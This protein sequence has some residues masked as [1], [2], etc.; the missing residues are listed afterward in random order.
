MSDGS[1][2]QAI[3]AVLQ[4]PQQLQKIFALAQSLGLSPPEAPAAP[5]PPEPP[6]PAAAATSAEQAPEDRGSALRTLLQGQARPPAGKPSQRAQTI[7]K[8]RATGKSG[9]RDAGSE[10][11]ASCRCSTARSGPERPVM[12][13]DCMYNRYTPSPDGTFQRTVVPDAPP[14]KPPEPEVCA[15]A[16]EPPRPQPPKPK[17]PSAP[18]PPKP[19]ETCMPAPPPV[20]PAPCPPDRPLRKL[21]PRG[22]DPGDLL[23][24]LVLL[25]VLMETD[26]DD[27]LT[28]LLTVAA[29]MLL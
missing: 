29:V 3:G 14:P 19:Q 11:L 24:L 18:P 15:C 5:P 25:L 12:G 27:T 7:F 22:I 16:Q 21:L 9:P 13:G 23:V 6:K 20:Q 8:A 2:E 26:E 10:N 4:D 1:L 28:I 17:P